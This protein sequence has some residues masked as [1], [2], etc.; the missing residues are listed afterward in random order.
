M[1]LRKQSPQPREE[2]R[3]NNRLSLELLKKMNK[4]DE[5][6]TTEANDILK[7]LLLVHYKELIEIGA[8]HFEYRRLLLKYTTQDLTLED[9]MEDEDE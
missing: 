7:N 3:V 9:F 8:L 4:L 6:N 1:K 2:G 5:Q